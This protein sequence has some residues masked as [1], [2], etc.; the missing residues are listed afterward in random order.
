M[1]DTAIIRMLKLKKAEKILARKRADTALSIVLNELAAESCPL[2]PGQK[3]IIKGDTFN[4]KTGIV[5][6][7]RVPKQII[8][9]NWEVSGFVLKKDGNKTRYDTFEIDEKTYNMSRA[10]TKI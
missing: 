7:V 9:N 8:D 2:T 5:R 4:G 1:K 6:Y 3:I 10:S